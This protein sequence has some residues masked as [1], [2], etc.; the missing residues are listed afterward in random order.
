M[1]DAIDLIEK[2]FP[3]QSKPE[4]FVEAHEDNPRTE[5]F[6]EF[7]QVILDRDDPNALNDSDAVFSVTF[8]LSWKERLKV[9]LTGRYDAMIGPFLSEAVGF[10][11]CWQHQDI[12]KTLRDFTR[13][14]SEGESSE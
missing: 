2:E 1:K 4:D 12:L 3:D 13:K 7:F 5:A 14:T 9:L 11:I 8:N 6:G 10:G